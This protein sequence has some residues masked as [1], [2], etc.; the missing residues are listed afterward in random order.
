MELS[1]ALRTSQEVYERLSDVSTVHKL[2]KWTR[3]DQGGTDGRNDNLLEKWSVTVSPSG[4]S[5]QTC[6]IELALLGTIHGDSYGHFSYLFICMC[7]CVCAYILF[8]FLFLLM[9]I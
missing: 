9:R 2:V 4:S 1:S 3:N 7:V 5:L 6:A 8:V